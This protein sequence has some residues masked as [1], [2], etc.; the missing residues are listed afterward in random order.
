[1]FKYKFHV[2]QLKKVVPSLILILFI[3]GLMLFSNTNLMAAK[4]GLTLW[5]NS[6]VPSLFPFFVA[7]E[8]LSKTN[9]VYFIGKFFNNIM[10]PF[11]NI[12]GEGSFALIMGLLSGY[13][14]GAK[15]ATNFRKNNVCSKE[16]C[17]RL[18]SFTNNSGPLFIIGSVGISMFGSSAI[19]FLLL[20]SHILA[21]ITVGFIFKFWKY[22]KK[23]K[24]SLNTY[25]SKHSNT[26]NI[27]NLGEVLGNCITSSINTILMIGGFVVIFSVILS[28]L[29]SSNILYIL[30]N[31]IKPIF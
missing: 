31:L 11:F 9:F 7:T 25:N 5:A 10:Y 4:K 14:V 13:P 12:P 20:I 15:I 17:E 29:N 8:L 19:G 3:I 23:S 16:E 18:L 2:I 22:N 27:S 24:T 28:I 26:L 6:I 21:S 30:C 1:M